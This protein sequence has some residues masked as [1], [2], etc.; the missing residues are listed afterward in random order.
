MMP[1]VVGAAV[2]AAV[3]IGVY[4]AGARAER[5]RGEA[6]SLR[7]RITVL[8]LDIATAEAMSALDRS[9]AASAEQAAQINSEHVDA[10]RKQ[11]EGRVCGPLT[12]RD[13]RGLRNIR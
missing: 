10:L 13:A 12:D 2:C 11:S 9:L 4:Q 3:L 5:E 7:S 1:A 8:K 6:A